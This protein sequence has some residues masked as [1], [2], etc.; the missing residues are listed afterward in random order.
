MQKELTDV[1]TNNIVFWNHNIKVHY[2][3]Y[4]NN[5]LMNATAYCG[6][7]YST[8]KDSHKYGTSVTTGNVI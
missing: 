1:R 4:I 8:L 3:V 2:T 6:I 7:S 5:M